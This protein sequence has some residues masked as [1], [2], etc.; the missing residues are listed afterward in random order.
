[1]PLPGVLGT[2]LHDLTIRKDRNIAFQIIAFSYLASVSD[3]QS[4]QFVQTFPVK[5]VL[6]RNNEVLSYLLCC[7]FYIQSTQIHIL[8]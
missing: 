8:F 3:S 6:I 1:M 2:P 4:C 5:G 7:L